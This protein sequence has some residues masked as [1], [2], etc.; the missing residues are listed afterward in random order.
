MNYGTWFRNQNPINWDSS[1]NYER[2]LYR[3]YFIYPAAV[4]LDTRIVSWNRLETDTHMVNFSVF[5]PR[6]LIK[7]IFQ[8]TV[9]WMVLLPYFF[10]IF[11]CTCTAWTC[12]EIRFCSGPLPLI[13]VL[14]QHAWN[15]LN[16]PAGEFSS[17]LLRQVTPG[18]QMNDLDHNRNPS[19]KCDWMSSGFDSARVG[20]ML[21]GYLKPLS[22][23]LTRYKIISGD[24]SLMW[25][26]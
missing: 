10:K 3:Q 20:R 15:S 16:S 19:A 13:S 9:E 2:S 11:H 14:A 4:H 1:E 24:R 25:R 21:T 6:N 26:V 17:G 12:Q 8:W 23:K 22:C 7:S 5:F 18:H